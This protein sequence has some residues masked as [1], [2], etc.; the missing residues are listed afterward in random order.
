V[1]KESALANLVVFPFQPFASLPDVLATGDVL[2]IS[3]DDNR[4]AYSNFCPGTM[5]SWG[6]SYEHLG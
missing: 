3:Q 6:L 2:T 1:P 5:E 4:S